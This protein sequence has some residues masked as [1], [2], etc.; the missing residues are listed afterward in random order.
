MAEILHMAEMI[1]QAYIIGYIQVF[2]LW[3]F[4]EAEQLGMKEIAGIVICTSIYTG[5]SYACKWFDRDIWVTAGFAA[6][7]VFLYVCVFFIYKCR[8]SIDDKILNADLELFKARQDRKK[9]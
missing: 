6:Y 5:I 9:E 4:D 8:R 2:L 1:F 3:N 7:I